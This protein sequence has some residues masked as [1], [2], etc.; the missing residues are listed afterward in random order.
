MAQH[1]KTHAVHRHTNEHNYVGA[2][3]CGWRTSRKTREL[4]ET[5][6][7]AH[8]LEHTADQ[9]AASIRWDGER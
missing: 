5:D 2:C 7:S 1:D 9:V 4:R 6:I 3:L 8:T